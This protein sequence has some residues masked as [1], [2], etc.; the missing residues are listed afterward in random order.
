MTRETASHYRCFCDEGI[1]LRDYYLSMICLGYFFDDE[2]IAEQSRSP[3]LL[4]NEDFL[5]GQ[6][7]NQS[8]GQWVEKSPKNQN[9][10][11]RPKKKTSCCL[12]R[13]SSSTQWSTREGIIS[14]SNS[15]RRTRVHSPVTLQRIE[16]IVIPR[17]VTN[18][19]C[20]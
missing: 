13:I 15:N 5:G 6:S 17:G 7:L 20:R 18:Q 4:S 12:P 1:L 19:N 10:N 8:F 9:Q 16:T 11:L 14:S 3:A 2:L